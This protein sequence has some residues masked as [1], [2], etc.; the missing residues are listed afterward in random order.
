M[1]E[2][3]LL[4]LN[5]DLLHKVED[6]II[7]CT[8]DNW[9]RL[10]LFTLFHRLKFDGGDSSFECFNRAIQNYGL[11]QPDIIRGKLFSPLSSLT[12]RDNEVHVSWLS[13]WWLKS[14]LFSNHVSWLSQWWLK[15][16]LFSNNNIFTIGI[17]LKLCPVCHLVI[18]D[19]H[20]FGLGTFQ[21][22]LISNGSCF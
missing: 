13:Q 19:I 11:W 8:Y 20:A 3:V 17:I 5:T 16:V 4:L 10:K 21:P 6:Y 12:R 15:S 2:V 1:S 9:E 7:G 18:S 14:V 22:S